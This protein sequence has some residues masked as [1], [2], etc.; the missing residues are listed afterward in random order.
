NIGIHQRDVFFNGFPLAFMIAFSQMLACMVVYFYLNIGLFT[1]LVKRINH[2]LPV[3]F[4]CLLSY[5][6][7]APIDFYA[8]FIGVVMLLLS[9]TVIVQ[10]DYFDQKEDAAAGRIIYV[11]K[12]DVMFFNAT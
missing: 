2:A 6:L 3:V 10:N 8:Y 1:G 4:T 11:N 5:S 9:F 7:I 12:D